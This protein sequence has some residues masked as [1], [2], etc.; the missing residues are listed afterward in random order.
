[1][2]KTNIQSALKDRGPISCAKI[3]CG[4]PAQGGN[5]FIYEDFVARTILN[6]SN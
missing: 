4:H 6:W 5:V 2:P 1:L 3:L